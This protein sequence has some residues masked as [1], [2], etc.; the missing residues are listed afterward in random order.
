[1]HN[2][3][4]FIWS[5][6]V[7]ASAA[8]AQVSKNCQ[9]LARRTHPGS[10]T[11]AGVW[12]YVHTDGSEY[13]CVGAN[14]GTWIVET[15]DP[16]NSVERGFIPGPSGSSGLWREING[17]GSYI[18]SVTEAGGGVQVI[19]MTNP[20]A[21]VL[22]RTVTRSGW[23]NTHSVSV[24][25][26][27]GKLYCNGASQG[28][29]IF[30]LTADPS[31]P[32]YLTTW[33]GT[34]AH[35][36]FA[37]H[38]YCYVAAINSGQMRI[39]N[40][41]SLPTITQISQTTTPGAFT[42]NVWVNSTDTIALTTDETSTGFMQVY[43]ISN[44]AMP[45]K[46]GKYSVAN[47]GIHNVF[48]VDDKVAHMSY[49]SAGYR[50]ADVSD[51]NNPQEI[52][53]YDASGMDSWG[54]YPFQPS[55]TVYVADF[56]SAG[57][58]Y[59]VRLTCGVPERY[60]TGTAGTSGVPKSDWSGGHARVGNSTFNLDLKGALGATPAV[61]LIGAAPASIPVFGVTLLVDLTMPAIMSS[62]VT[63]ASGTASVPTAIPNWQA[64]ANQSVYAQ[65]IVA[66][67]SAPQGFAATAG[68][69]ITICANNG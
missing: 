58:L 55:G 22:L 53:Y 60:G 54:C 26:T 16:V 57:G 51:P 32:A 34:Y 13:A 50:A 2:K 52:G 63:S 41:A 11:Y 59:V 68:A 5:A 24:D 69:K 56:G 15:T 28:M 8:S 18:Y 25:Q 6:V 20:R 9:L 40:V 33:S 46:R 62:T 43:D 47:R 67:P 3:S 66:D 12:G 19:D 29:M 17:Y 39:L 31:N 48:L 35:D 64:L 65:W 61:L 45:V 23:S 38:G 37:Q 7:L 10:S 4:L 27:A 36:S 44:K 1:M 21:P 49:Y 14:N 42:H 30:D